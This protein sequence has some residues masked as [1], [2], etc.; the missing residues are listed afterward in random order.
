MKINNSF[1]AKGTFLRNGGLVMIASIIGALANW[2]QLTLFTKNFTLLQ[3]GVY[4]LAISISAPV[5]SLLR[6]GLSPLYVADI[7]RKFEYNNY[8]SL[9]IVSVFIS[10][11]IG[12]I[13]S[14]FIFDTS[15]N[16]T[17]FFLV[18]CMYSI[19]A[20]RD[21]FESK[22]HSLEKFNLMSSSVIINSIISF[23]GVFFGVFLFSDFVIALIF[24]VFFKILIVYFYNYKYLF[25][26][27][28]NQSLQ[29]I[30]NKRIISLLKYSFYLGV[31]VAID[32][33]NVNVSKYFINNRFGIEYQGAFSAMSYL[34][35]IGTLLVTTLGK[36]ILP[37]VSKLLVAKKFTAIL[38]YQFI[39]SLMIFVTGLLLLIGA[40]FFNEII[41]ETFFSKEI[42]EFSEIFVWI[43]GAAIFLFLSSGQGYLMTAINIVKLQ[44]LVA[45]IGLSINLVLNFVFIDQF[46]VKGIIV[47]SGISFLTQ[48]LINV[49]IFYRKI[50]SENYKK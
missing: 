20:I 30:V 42:A 2:L 26:F 23:S 29:F 5:I 13:I 25:Q 34:I 35:V 43:M 6:F 1:F 41:I 50:G 48:Y 49:F 14:F 16:S 24:A 9:R 28:L 4:T 19:D 37:K 7:E 11:L 47:S 44:P 22:Y 27:I 10:L 3:I 18:F 38:K 15:V 32:S 39:Y 17:V 31:Y 45:L 36:L 8:F 46:G 12:L 40:Y 33:L 21:I